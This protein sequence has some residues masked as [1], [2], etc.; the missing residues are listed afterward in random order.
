MAK[1]RTFVNKGIDIKDSPFD[2]DGFALEAENL[3]IT[4]GFL[5]SH[6][7][8]ALYKNDKEYKKYF[9]LFKDTIIDF[10][11]Y[12][13]FLEYRNLLLY[14]NENGG[15]KYDGT[16]SYTLGIEKPDNITI[17][18]GSGNLTGTYQYAYTYYNSSDNT[19]SVPILSDSLTL[20]N[21]NVT[22]SI[23]ASTNSQ[24]DKIRIYRIGG[25][26]TSFTLVNTIDNATT[27]YTDNISDSSI[28]GNHIMDTQD[29]NPYPKGAKQLVYTQGIIVSYIDDKLI[30]SKIG[31]PN[32][33][34]AANYI[35]FESDITGIGVIASGLLIFLANKTYIIQGT[36]PELF[37]KFLLSSD[38]G[39]KTP[40]SIRYVNNYIVWASDDGICTTNGGQ[41]QILSLNLLDKI[42]LDIVSSGVIDSKYFA[43]LSNGKILVADFRFGMA[44]YYLDVPNISNIQQVKPYDLLLFYNNEDKYLYSLNGKTNLTFTY[45][46][47]KYSDGI[48]SR[49]KYYQQI[50]LAY[51]GQLHIN[52][53]I[54]DNLVLSTDITRDLIK[55]PAVKQRGRWIQFEITGT[56]E[57][58]ELSYKVIKENNENLQQ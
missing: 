4:K 33:W 40:K 24:V 35:K 5:T 45:L 30:W 31:N 51:K 32:Y 13:F 42:S 6:K 19:E 38:Q 17:T 50:Y 11:I 14:S 10:D 3:D 52:V 41:I 21:N 37:T 7:N 58:Y 53:Y 28:A 22:I 44:F 8:L 36:S 26:I 12:T 25:S 46:S 20:S 47:P 57:L 48:L 34:P 43:L 16:N 1:I 23:S 54:D 9:Y 55:L 56:G 15:F 2:L 49:L 29:N 39:C 27:A 18:T